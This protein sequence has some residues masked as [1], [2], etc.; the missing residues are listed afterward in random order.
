MNRL[1]FIL[2]FIWSC[3]PGSNNATYLKLSDADKAKFDKY[4][5][6]GKDVYN[7]TCL[8]CHQKDGKGLHGLIPPLANS[9]YLREYQNE[10]PCL[11]HNGSIDSLVVNGRTYPPQMPAHDI[12]NLELAEVVTYINNSWGNDYGFMPVKQV[13]QLLSNCN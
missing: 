12:S 9:D 11:L 8:N 2:L 4:M 6:L 3:G 10:I 1:F 5:I 13:D 7:I